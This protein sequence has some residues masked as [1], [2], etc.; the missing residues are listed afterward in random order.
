[1]RETILNILKDATSKRKTNGNEDTNSDAVR[2]KCL[3]FLSR[4]KKGGYANKVVG[5][6][7]A[8]CV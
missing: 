2:E 1:M 3:V 8:E 6:F 5:V 7:R 4:K